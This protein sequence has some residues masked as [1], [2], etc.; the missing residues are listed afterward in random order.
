[1][2]DWIREQLRR[3]PAWMNGL[4]LFCAWMAFVYV[5][6]D[7][8]VK[9]VDQDEEAWFGFVVH[10]WA[11]KATAP[12]HWAIYA[13]AA[14]G[15]WHMRSWMWPWA[16]VYAGY[17]ALSMAIWP[18]LRYGGARGA[19]LGG[20]V[21]VPLAALAV[22]LW[23]ARERFQ[24]ERA[25]LR[26]RYGEWALVTGASAGIG[27]EFARALARDGFSVVLSA[28]REDRLRDVAAELEKA[29]AVST[30]VVPID[31]GATGGAE[32]LAERAA[33][34]EIGV[35]VNNAGFGYAGSFERQDPARLQEMVELNCAAPVVLT[36]RLLPGM[37]ARGKGA[38]IVVGSAAGAQ[39]LPLHAVYAA[40]KAFDRFFGEALWAE[41]RGSGIDVL[42]LEPGPTATEFQEVA[43]AIPHPGESP[44]RVVA[45]ALE[46]LGRQPSVLYGWWNWLRG[47][48]GARLLPRSL[49]VV[50]AQ[51][52]MARQTPPEMR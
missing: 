7:L 24:P 23:R 28:R 19:L 11:A 8:F 18:V 31:L 39:P 10:G 40:T 1:M 26:K 42:V 29:H 34:L 27:L 51:G 43:G 9:P 41:L 3:R 36:A 30:R 32:A 17:V 22:A 4:L 33:D 12:I 5:P 44:D 50:L 6:W 15:F 20:A 46:R 16:S 35:L 25:S 2:L 21:F 37:R 47:N 13:A 38:V 49:L 52:V 45:L 14:Y 48:A